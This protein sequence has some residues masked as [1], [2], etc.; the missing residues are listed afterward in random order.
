M[1]YF[2]RVSPMNMPGYFEFRDS[3]TSA[4]LASKPLSSVALGNGSPLNIGAFQHLMT[5]V[6][7]P[8]LVCGTNL[9]TKQCNLD[10]ARR[11]GWRHAS[12]QNHLA[13]QEL[14]HAGPSSFSCKP[15]GMS[16]APSRH[17]RG[18]PSKHVRW[19]EVT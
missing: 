4:S 13:A 10:V 3:G 7:Y 12:V 15:A 18:E 16:P 11:L 9:Q 17:C 5:I 1:L 19:L 6:G 8:V 2:Q 14:F